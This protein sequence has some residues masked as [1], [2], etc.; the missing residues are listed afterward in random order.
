MS[1]ALAFTRRADESPAVYHI[2]PQ[3]DTVA[4]VADMI[5]SNS[6]ANPD[7]LFLVGTYTIGKEEVFLAPARECGWKVGA[8][9]T[10]DKKSQIV[11]PTALSMKMF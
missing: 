5:R 7:T 4:F 11:L 8:T 1:T 6:F 9:L 2:S 10:L 3:A